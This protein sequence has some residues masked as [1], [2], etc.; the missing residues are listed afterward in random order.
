MHMT[1][2]GFSITSLEQGSNIPIN[3]YRGWPL[4][5]ICINHPPELC[6][7]CKM[8]LG[9]MKICE[10]CDNVCHVCA[11][12]SKHNGNHCFFCQGPIIIPR[13][14]NFKCEKCNKGFT[15]N[16][17]LMFECECLFCEICY[18]SEVDGRENIQK[19]KKHSS[20]NNAPVYTNSKIGECQCGGH[21][22]YKLCNKCPSFCEKCSVKC[23]ENASCCILCATKLELQRNRYDIRCETCSMVFKLENISNLSCWCIFCSRC[24]TKARKLFMNEYK[25]GK[26][27]K[28]VN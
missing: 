6:S 23:K 11:I 8:R 4:Y 20:H 2:T 17:I 10:R 1:N 19:C 28:K 21:G 27:S 5:C 26:C 22:K 9:T 3:K 18:L 25:C 15:H 16:Q 24:L 13:E 7:K 12:G 14:A